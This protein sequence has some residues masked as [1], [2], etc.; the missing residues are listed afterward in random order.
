MLEK[1]DPGPLAS[2]TL[3]CMTAFPASHTSSDDKES[4]NGNRDPALLLYYRWALQSLTVIT[5]LHEHGVYLMD[6]GA[7]TIWIRDDLSIALTGFLGATIP[8]DECPFSPVG[9]RYEADIYNPINPMTGNPEMD[10][11]IDIADWA[12]FVWRMMRNDA[13]GGVDGWELPTDHLDPTESSG[14]V[15][16]YEEHKQQVKEGKFQLLEEERLGPILVKA[17]KG[18]YENARDVLQEVRSYFQHIGVRMEGED[19]VLLDDGRNWEDVFR[20]VP[21]EWVRWARVLEYKWHTRPCVCCL[22]TQT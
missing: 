17:W 3:P 13:T 18:E 7:R 15:D 11:K 16:P 5:F 10:P 1:L 4:E 20:V 21:R 14:D 6:F 19:E 8:T 12:T 9:S 2:T 22:N